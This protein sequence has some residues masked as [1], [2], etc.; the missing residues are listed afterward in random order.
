MAVANEY[1]H[2]L[3]DLS[4]R[5]YE[6]LFDL[7]KLATKKAHVP[8]RVL[9]FSVA[10]SR[11]LDLSIRAAIRL[12]VRL[13]SIFPLVK[14]FVEVVTPPRCGRVNLDDPVWA[15][16]FR[17]KRKIFIFCD[18]NTLAPRTFSKHKAWVLEGIRPRKEAASRVVSFVEELR[19]GRP[20]LVGL[21]VRRE[22]YETY[23]NGKYFFS[24]AAYRQVA[25]RMLKLLRGRKV[26]FFICSIDEEDFSVFDGLDFLFR[27]GHPIENLYTLSECDYIISVP[28]TYAMWASLVGGVPAYFLETTDIDFDLKDFLAF[29]G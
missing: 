1:G 15:E 19:H 28:S 23:M 9:G 29:S 5:E 12:L 6:P 27:S 21:V 14:R 18:W 11:T 13:Q 26:R 22:D 7:Q 16:K 24:M 17:E 4:L 2:S 20:F 10:S 3:V 25:D 8:K